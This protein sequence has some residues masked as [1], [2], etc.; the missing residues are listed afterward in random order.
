MW[1]RDHA[2]I[3]DFRRRFVAGAGS[4]NID[5]SE[6]GVMFDLIAR[7]GPGTVC[8]ANALTTAHIGYQLAWLKSHFPAEFE[9]A[10]R[11]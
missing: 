4:S 11:S 10:C 8:K 3:D 9:T 5:A 6:A 7:R 2:R 1:K